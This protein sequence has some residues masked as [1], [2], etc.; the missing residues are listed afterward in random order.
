MKLF[1][2]QNCG[3][4]LYFENTR[5]ESC[6][7]ALGY[8][9]ERE[10]I[11]ALKPDGHAPNPSHQ[12]WRALADNSTYYYCA[13]AGYDVCNWLVQASTPGRLLLRLPPQPHDS[14]PFIC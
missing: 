4:P 11:T 12:V 2:C 14:R 6:G 9:P 5:C 13:N 8:L 10:M 7:L 3:Q 1:Q